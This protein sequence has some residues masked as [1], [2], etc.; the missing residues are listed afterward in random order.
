MYLAAKIKNTSIYKW[1]LFDCSQLKGN[2]HATDVGKVC[3]L[4]PTGLPVC[5]YSHLISVPVLSNIFHIVAYMESANT[6]NS[7][8]WKL[9]DKLFISGGDPALSDFSYTFKWWRD[10]YL[11][12]LLYN[13][14][15]AQDE[16]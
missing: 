6:Y 15:R 9:E 16:T 8:P 13:P 3:H 5:F 1:L 4:E 10:Q 14:F 12:I 7:T 2:K 11:S